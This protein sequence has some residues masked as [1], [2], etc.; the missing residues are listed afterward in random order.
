MKTLSTE[1][2]GKEAILFGLQVHAQGDLREGVCRISQF[3]DLCIGKRGCV[4]NGRTVVRNKGAKESPVVRGIKAAYFGIYDDHSTEAG[5]AI[6]R[7]RIFR[8]ADIETDHRIRLERGQQLVL[9]HQV[10]LEN[11]R[12]AGSRGRHEQAACAVGDTVSG[13]EAA[14]RNVVAAYSDDAGIA[15]FKR[16]NQSNRRGP[17]HRSKIL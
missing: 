16:G 12:R 10:D 13:A 5:G 14:F 8:N 1:D 17:S 3:S 4:G 6:S 11:K 15:T 7:V 2:G 9:A